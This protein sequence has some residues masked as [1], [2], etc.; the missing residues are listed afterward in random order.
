MNEQIGAAAARLTQHLMGTP[1]FVT[2][3]AAADKII[4]FATSKKLQAPTEWEGFPVEVMVSGR[5][6]PL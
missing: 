4:C 2:A 1:G 6:R 3:G 5:P